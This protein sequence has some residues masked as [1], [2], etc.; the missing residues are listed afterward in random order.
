MNPSWCWTGH[1]PAG[2]NLL[3][4]RARGGHLSRTLLVRGRCQGAALVD[5]DARPVRTL[6][7]LL[8]HCRSTA[9]PNRGHPERARS[10]HHGHTAQHAQSD[11][12]RC[13][14]V[15]AF[16]PRRARPHRAHESQPEHAGD[17]PGIHKKSVGVRGLRRSERAGACVF[18]PGDFEAPRRAY[19]REPPRSCN[20]LGPRLG[21]WPLPW[22]QRSQTPVVWCESAPPRIGPSQPGGSGGTPR[23]SASTP[24]R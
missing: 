19:G 15:Q 13:G 10:H 24:G 11:L 7:R 2:R 6:A 9:T 22:A 21:R 1:N 8:R 3:C 4:E 18:C 5:D 17:D 12:I 23:G 14:G 16:A 20:F